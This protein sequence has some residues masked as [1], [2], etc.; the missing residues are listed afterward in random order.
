[1]LCPSDMYMHCFWTKPTQ[2]F[3]RPGCHYLNER[4][5]SLQLQT[6]LTVTPNCA[7]FTS[8]SPSE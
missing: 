8:A 7:F 5:C 2:S 3:M 6:A 4:F 1:M